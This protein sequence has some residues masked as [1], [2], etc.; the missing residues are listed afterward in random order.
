MGIIF[1]CLRRGLRADP[2][3]DN[4]N[5]YHVLEH[6]ELQQTASNATE[7]PLIC[8]ETEITERRTEHTRS[9]INTPIQE[10][11]DGEE[12]Q[13]ELT[14][15]ETAFGCG[16]SRLIVSVST[17]KPIAG[18]IKPGHHQHDATVNPVQECYVSYEHDYSGSSSLVKLGVDYTAIKLDSPCLKWPFERAAFEHSSAE[19]AL[20]SFCQA[21]TL[22][23]EV[24]HKSLTPLTP[25]ITNHVLHYVSASTHARTHV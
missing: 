16:V 20:G 25:V 7:L 2:R 13:L 6:H 19:K 3:T 15:E 1:C 4:Y 14:L 5:D 8:D 21:D 11:T 9:S 24:E 12:D 18:F 22:V 17:Q 10:E 23:A